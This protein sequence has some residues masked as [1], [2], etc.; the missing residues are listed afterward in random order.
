M[1]CKQRGGPEGSWDRDSD[2][3]AP[4]RALAGQRCCLSPSPGAQQDREGPRRQSRS[5]L[6]WLH[7]HRV[8]SYQASPPAAHQQSRTQH[9]GNSW[10]ATEISHFPPLTGIF[11]CRVP[12][13]P[14]QKTG[15]S[16][17][18]HRIFGRTGGALTFP[19]NRKTSQIRGFSHGKRFYIYTESTALVLALKPQ[20]Q[21]QTGSFFSLS[22]TAGL[23]R[24]QIHSAPELPGMTQGAAEPWLQRDH[25]K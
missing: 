9:K 23:R 6:C 24:L 1:L 3:A 2:I 14:P 4:P 21:A 7:A 15:Q 8:L 20:V 25:F 22:L 12:P 5:W 11:H 19:T 17:F 10:A 16:C 18:I 13:T